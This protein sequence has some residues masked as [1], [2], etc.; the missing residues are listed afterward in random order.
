[1]IGERVR[2]AR[3]LCGLSLRELAKKVGV[4][5]QA[6]SK[7]E[8]N[9]DIPGSETLLKLASAL[10][11]K[12]EYFFRPITVQLSRPVY[13]CPRGKLGIREEE[14]IK[15][16]VA[17]WIERYLSIESLFSQGVTFHI[18]EIAR[19]LNKEDDVENIALS[20]R[21][22]WQLGYDALNSLGETL[23]ERGI[24][25]GVF[26][27]LG[28]VDAISFWI[29][30]E[31]TPVIVVR[32]GVPGDRQR[33]SIAHELGH[34]VLDIPKQWQARQVEKA[35][36]RFAGA[37]LVPDFVVK[38]ELGA[39]RHRIDIEELLPLKHKYGLSMQA[40]IH[41]AE[42]LKIISKAEA[43]RLRKEFKKKGWKEKEPGDQYPPER[44]SRFERLV[45]RALS[46]GI[47]SRSRAVELLS[48]SHH[49]L[50]ESNYPYGFSY[51]QAGH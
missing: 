25:I 40:W 20:L 48:F 1:M 37:F 10:G 36:N 9:K 16:R 8:R 28:K 41:R 21:E 3:Q 15:R 12:V 50:L 6:I 35:V 34:I 43:L 42:D 11:V 13:R 38:Q 30:G 19:S 44:L 14:K 22:F 26:Q 29:D 5:A 31:N 4:S 39:R 17:E 33:F 49:K 7:Y 18:P 51:I 2:S 45:Y 24:K 32:D 27:E 47:I 46:E 23:E